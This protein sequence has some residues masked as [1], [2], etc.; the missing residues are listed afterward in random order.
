MSDTDEILTNEATE[1]VDP[2]KARVKESKPKRP[3]GC[4]CGEEVSSFFKPGHDAKLLSQLSKAVVNQ[5]PDD[6]SGLAQ[7]VGQ[8]DD[9]DVETS[10][11][12]TRDVIAQEFNETLAAKFEGIARNALVVAE[13]RRKAAEAK[14]AKANETEEQKAE[15][16]R[17]AAEK[18]A[19]KEAKAA[20]SARKK[21]EREAAR[22]QKAEEAAA[23][24]AERERIA[25][26]K[27]EAAARAKEEAAATKAAAVA[28]AKAEQELQNAAE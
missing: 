1:I 16:E 2:P 9:Y 24:K 22:I 10:I 5:D 25:L 27:K 12:E 19:A 23:K 13:R 15:R 8:G 18:L 4:G 26:E 21:E 14:A 17:I 11:V 3:C 20:E 6:P 7:R 28:E